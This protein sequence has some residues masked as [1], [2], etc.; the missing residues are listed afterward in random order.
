[1]REK[2][3]KHFLMNLSYLLGMKITIISGDK[4]ERGYLD[5]P[6]NQFG[7]FC[8]FNHNDDGKIILTGHIDE[9]KKVSLLGESEVKLIKR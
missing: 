9:I 1:M 3:K 8:L 7:Q 4:K 5:P 2:M 6:K